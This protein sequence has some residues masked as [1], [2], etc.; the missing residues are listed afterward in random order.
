MADNDKA[1]YPRIPESNWWILR[2][3]FAKSLPKEVTVGYLKSLLQLQNENS[4]RNLLPPLKQIG[5]IDDDGKP[6]DRANSWRNDNTYSK[7]CEDIIEN[8]YPQELRDLFDSTAEKNAVENWFQ[9]DAKLG[10]VAAK[11][12]ASLYLLL[13]DAQPKNGNDLKPATS[14]K[15]EQSARE[16]KASNKKVA[17]N[18]PDSI[19]SENIAPSKH[20]ENIHLNTDKNT[21]KDWFSLH[22]DLQ[23]HISPE[24]TANQIDQIFESIAKHIVSMQMFKRNSNESE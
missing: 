8:V 7:V 19:N 22:I 16:K 24:A 1:V 18:K 6:T 23:I 3:Q 5:L 15:R 14:S 10:A 2:D 21:D 13:R 20:I 11:Q 4:A 17:A 9:Y 12:C